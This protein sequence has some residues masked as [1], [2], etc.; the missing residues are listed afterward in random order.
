MLISFWLSTTARYSTFRMLLL[1]H[2]NV[3]EL[4][5]VAGQGTSGFRIQAS[6]LSLDNAVVAFVLG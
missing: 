5:C 6:R 4:I 3:P 2:S 1:M